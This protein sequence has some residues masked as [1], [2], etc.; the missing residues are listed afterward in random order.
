MRR[1]A[2]G[3]RDIG[4]AGAANE[5]PVARRLRT[6]GWGDVRLWLGIALVGVAMVVGSAVLTAGADTITVMRAGRDLSVGAEPVDLV[7]VAVNRAAAGDAYLTGEVPAG[8]VLKW[9]VLAGE[10]VPR[11]ALGTRAASPTRRVTVPVDPLHAPAGLQ[12]GDRVDVWS[13]ADRGAAAPDTPPVEVLGD[14]T[15]V[16]LASEAVGMAGEMGVVLEVGQS[17]VAA[18]VAASRTGVIDLVAVPAG[19]VRAAPGP[20]DLAALS[21]NR[22]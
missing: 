20:T 19:S 22:P 16:G 21:G 15:V 7:P 6:P 2:A 17:D 12:G 8:A 3:G 11:S 14:V 5:Q 1:S 10:L 4:V 9:P 18:L 13:S